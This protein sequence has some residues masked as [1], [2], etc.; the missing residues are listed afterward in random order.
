VRDAGHD[1]F[2]KEDVLEMELKILSALNFK[3]QSKTVFE[4]ASIKLK[5]TML[6]RCK[7]AKKE[8]L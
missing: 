2:R 4:E 6:Q 1:K 8:N 7:S 5:Q 3:V